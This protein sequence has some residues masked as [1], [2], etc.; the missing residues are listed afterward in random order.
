MIRPTQHVTPIHRLEPTIRSKTYHTN[1]LITQNVESNEHTINY[2]TEEAT[3]LCQIFTQT[4]NLK[5]E[6][7][8]FGDKVLDATLEEVKKI[9]E[10]KCFRPIGV[11]KLTSQ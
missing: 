8:N 4:Y 7:K 9:Y 1:H 2:T 5:K 3:V 11:N 6:I 10:R